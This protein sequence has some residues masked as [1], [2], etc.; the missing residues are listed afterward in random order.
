MTLS[1]R[2]RSAC[3]GPPQPRRTRASEI[4]AAPG[5]AA[6]RRWFAHQWRKR[7]FAAKLGAHNSTPTGPP[8][9]PS[10]H[11]PFRHLPHACEHLVPGLGPGWSSVHAG[12]PCPLGSPHSASN[13][14]RSSML[15][16]PAAG[17]LRTPATTRATSADRRQSFPNATK[18]VMN[19]RIN[20]YSGCS[21]AA[22]IEDALPAGLSDVARS[23]S[24]RNQ[25]EI[26]S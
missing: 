22:S 12:G 23:P 26:V 13:P 11:L 20:S 3:I 16:S 15:S 17:R 6:R 21:R 24:G 4:F 19:Q 14:S 7:S 2:H 5:L 18:K 10:M 25:V 1:A 9:S 8:Q